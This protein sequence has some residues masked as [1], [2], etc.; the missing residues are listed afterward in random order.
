MRIA[1]FD[2]SV[3]RANA[4]GNCHRTILE[5]LCRDHKF[6]V[7]AVEFDNPCPEHITSVHVPAPRRPLALQFISYHVLAP[8]CYLAYRLRHRLS[9]DLVQMVESNLSFGDISYAHFCHRGFLRREASIRASGLRGWFRWLDHLLHGMV[10]PWVFGRVRHVV[11]PSEGLARDLQAEHPQAAGK[12]TVL[13]NPVDLHRMTP[14]ADFD[15]RAGRSRLGLSDADLAVVFVAQGNFE[16]KGLP[17]LLEAI[18]RIDD[19]RLKLVVV[20]GRPDL[21]R[22]YQRT[23]MRMELG[24]RVTFAGWQDDVRPFLWA[25]DALALPSAYETFSLVL[26]EA[27]AVGLPLVVTETHGTGDLVINGET[28]FVVERT[29]ESV[30]GGLWALLSL[31]EDER[32]QLGKQAQAMVQRYAVD[33]FTERWAQVYARLGAGVSGSAGRHFGRRGI[34]S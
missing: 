26:R 33:A 25:S 11:V 16:H 34:A 7:F 17:L 9:F 30:A 15:R 3:V 18:Q 10:E 24:E 14:P 4:I 29:T 12:V 2:H 1:I 21:V 27:A 32:R 19:G 8:L 6:T 13:S 22:T 28:G 5:G 31:S 20:G 23:V